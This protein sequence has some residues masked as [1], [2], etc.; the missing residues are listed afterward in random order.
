MMKYATLFPNGKELSPWSTELRRNNTPS[1]MHKKV[2]EEINTL[3]LDFVS[4]NI[5]K[6]L[7]II[8]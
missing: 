8:Q 1:Y 3:T 6:Y 7:N 4:L 5:W 2:K